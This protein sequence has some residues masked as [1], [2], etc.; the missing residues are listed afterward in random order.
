MV[1]LN[2]GDLKNPVLRMA[3]RQIYNCTKFSPKR[4]RVIAKTCRILDKEFQLVDSLYDKLIEEYAERDENGNVK[5]RPERGP[6]SFVVDPAK[7]E[8]FREAIAK[9]DGVEAEVEGVDFTM[10]DLEVVGDLSPAQ[11]ACLE[12]FIQ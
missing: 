9:V 11:I 6:G 3:T 2:Q 1:T 5:S 12:P 7:E 10:D 4:A 8:A